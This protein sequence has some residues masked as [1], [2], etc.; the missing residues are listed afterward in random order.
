MDH[1]EGTGAFTPNHPGVKSSYQNP[2]RF[3]A[4]WRIAFLALPALAAAT[5]G[6]AQP[7]PD[8]V[9]PLP[10]AIDALFKTWDRRDTPG[11]AL[12]V[13]RDGRVAYARGY[14]M[15][16]LEHDVPI[17]PASVFQIASVSKQFTAMSA[18]LLAGQGKLSLEDDV[19]K[20]VPEMHDFGKP[21][22]VRH[23]IHH[24]SGLRDQF[25]LLEMAGWGFSDAT[26]QDD[27]LKL[28]YRQR[29]LN[30]EPGAEFLYCNT[31][32]TLL[33]EVVRRASGNS[34]RQYAR[35]SIF[36]PLGMLSTHVHD[37]SRMLVKDRAHSYVPRRGGYAQ[38][39]L[40]ASEVGATNLFTTIED[41][42]RWDAN[43][44]SGKVGGPAALAEMLRKGRLNNGKEVNYAGGLSHGTH[45]G[46]PT[47]S[48]NGVHAG[49]RTTF[50][51][52]P[53]QRLSVIVLANLSSI[54][55]APLARRVADLYL[56]PLLKKEPAHKAA[57]KPAEPARK[58]EPAL[59]EAYAGQ[60]RFR[61]GLARTFVKEGDR[62]LMLNGG[63]R[64]PM[65]AVSD[66]ELYAEGFTARYRFSSPEAGKSREVVRQDEG[67][68]TTGRRLE[69][70]SPTQ[71]DLEACA[72]RYYSP[73]LEVIY[74]LDTRDGKLTA[75][76]RRG[77]V[78]LRP[79][80]RDEWD[81][82]LATFTFARGRGGKVEGFLLNTSRSRNIRFQ[83]AELRLGPVAK[84]PSQK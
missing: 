67:E 26:T 30:F 66:R 76:H 50:V 74:T 84:D 9:T 47:L 29:D 53:E 81:S 60:Y 69:P 41:L 51:R 3:A 7:T 64:L 54:T 40:S 39:I 19:R 38:A 43:F 57:P 24:T 42:A 32:Y 11:C 44:L 63:S 82:S 6:G 75:T 15:A 48:H 58:L 71:S 33:A 10:A 46:L 73:E 79:V 31:G 25:D 77:E 17:T 14:G 56:A 59:L 78:T 80:T 49:Y 45:R 5:Q 8:L 22:R 16:D 12:A 35:E 20:H 2:R 83:R 27:L 21:I 65:V 1:C 62:L 70:Y 18:V 68:E 37:D 4:M 23:L 55:P 36:L 34:L 52:F 61:P 28:A 72:G 13:V